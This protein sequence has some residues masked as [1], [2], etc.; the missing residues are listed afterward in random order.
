[1]WLCAAEGRAELT[2]EKREREVMDRELALETEKHNSSWTV[3][4]LHA[5]KSRS[6][7]RTATPAGW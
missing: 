3:K 7:R 4:W 2:A 6:R 1:M 5:V